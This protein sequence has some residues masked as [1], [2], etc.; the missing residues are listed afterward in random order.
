MNFSNKMAP[1]VSRHSLVGSVFG[2]FDVKPGFM[3]QARHQNKLQKNISS[4]MS[5]QQVSGK[6]SNGVF[7]STKKCALYLKKM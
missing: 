1:R 2:L 6:N 7:F 3:H 5:F 4:A